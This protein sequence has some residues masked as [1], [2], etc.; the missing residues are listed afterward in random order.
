MDVNH[1]KRKISLHSD[2]HNTPMTED[3]ENWLKKKKGKYYGTNN[4][5]DF[6]FGLL[7]GTG[8][9][10]STTAEENKPEATHHRV[11]TL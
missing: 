1:R 5:A 3:Y 8:R 6:F 9:E 10:Y 11:N 7:T 2:T 4:V